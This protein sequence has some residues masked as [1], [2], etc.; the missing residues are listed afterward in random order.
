MMGPGSEP[1]YVHTSTGGSSECS[2]TSAG[3][4]CTRKRY[5]CSSV[6]CGCKM[7]GTR[8]ASLNLVSDVFG[9]VMM[10]P[11]LRCGEKCRFS[12]RWFNFRNIHLSRLLSLSALFHCTN[13]Y[14][15]LRDEPSCSKGSIFSHPPLLPCA[16]S[17]IAFSRA[18]LLIVG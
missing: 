1:S 18:D 14:N 11:L 7:E 4:I 6:W 12:F 10:L 2:W 5:R 3:R 9:S 17:N 15:A 16:A 8:K 13:H